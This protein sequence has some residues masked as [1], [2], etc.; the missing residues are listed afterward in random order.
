M[1]SCSTGTENVNASVL[2]ISGNRLPRPIVTSPA[3][4]FEPIFSPD[5]RWLAYWSDD[6]TERSAVY[7]TAFPGP[8]GRWKVSSGS[9]FDS[10][11]TSAFWWNGSNE[12]DYLS[13]DESVMA[14]DLKRNGNSMSVSAAHGI[15]GQ[16]PLPNGAC[17]Y[18]PL[19]KRFLIAVPAGS[20][21]SFITVITN[22]TAV[23]EKR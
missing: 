19:L 6:P 12:I 21:T 11:Q 9:V 17:D 1:I 15:P 5:G 7:V 8:G 4:S 10:I 18:S 22:W 20:P 3:V 23:L 2:P 16:V 14:V 13:P